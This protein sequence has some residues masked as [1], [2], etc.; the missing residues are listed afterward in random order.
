MTFP[1]G[2]RQGFNRWN[3]V[4]LQQVEDVFLSSTALERMGN[5]AIDKK[6]LRGKV[7]WGT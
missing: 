5:I 7:R 1:V 3:G 4:A 6:R 2:V